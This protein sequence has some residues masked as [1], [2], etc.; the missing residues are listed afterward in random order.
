MPAPPARMRSARVP[1]GTSSSS[2]S[3]AWYCRSKRLWRPPEARIAK[4]AITVAS[5]RSSHSS[6]SLS[7]SPMLF[8]IAVSP[9]VPRRCSARIRFDGEPAETKPPTI[10]VAPSSTPSSAASGVS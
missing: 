10:T 5:C 8:A 6:S 9:R 4:L 7:P 2:T 1:C 3:P